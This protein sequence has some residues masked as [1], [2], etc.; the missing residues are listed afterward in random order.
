MMRLDHGYT[1]SSFAMDSG[2]QNIL[3]LIIYS[4]TMLDEDKRDRQ[5]FWS[6]HIPKGAPN[7]IRNK[8]KENAHQLIKDGFLIQKPTGYGLEVSLNFDKKDE[9]F[10]IIERWKL[11][12]D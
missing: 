9:I 11:K 8:I 2:E 5:T 1:I 4:S 12:V 3:V 10:A 6:R 7:H